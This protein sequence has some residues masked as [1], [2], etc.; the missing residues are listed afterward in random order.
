MGWGGNP[1]GGAGKDGF[2]VKERFIYS[3]LFG[4]ERGGASLKIPNFLLAKSYQFAKIRTNQRHRCAL[5]LR[6]VITFHQSFFK[7]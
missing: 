5:S 3:W 1:R 6:L 7:S 4:L 2:R